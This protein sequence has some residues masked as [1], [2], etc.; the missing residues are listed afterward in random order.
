VAA[1]QVGAG[2]VGAE[3]AAAEQVAAEQVGAGRVGAEQA[4]AEQVG[5]GR[6]AEPAAVALARPAATG[7]AVRVYGIPEVLRAAVAARELD[8]VAEVSVVEVERAGEE[9]P[10]AAEEGQD[11]AAGRLRVPRALHLENG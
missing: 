2:R 4:A 5:A 3:Q 9:E 1:E 10:E 11:P 7:L 6:V 8:P